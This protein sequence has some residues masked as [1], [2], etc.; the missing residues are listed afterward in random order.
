M[1]T[2]TSQFY[3]VGMQQQA[4][5]LLFEIQ[6]MCLCYAETKPEGN[7][8]GTRVSTVLGASIHLMG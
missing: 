5:D 3:T 6:G 2:K 7:Y 8:V 1:H 4:Q